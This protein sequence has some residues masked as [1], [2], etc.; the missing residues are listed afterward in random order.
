MKIKLLE[1]T[2]A[3]L[4]I[5][6]MNHA[7]QGQ[8]NS[9][10]QQERE[11]LREQPL[12]SSSILKVFF[13]DLTAADINTLNQRFQVLEADGIRLIAY[14]LSDKTVVV[15]YSGKPEEQRRIQKVFFD[16]GLQFFYPAH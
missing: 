11:T 4:F 2:L 13:K 1:N 14:S 15:S 3:I 6:T 12:P 5:I 8:R 9:A 10:G 7:A 16:S